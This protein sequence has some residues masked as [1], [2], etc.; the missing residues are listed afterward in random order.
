MFKEGDEQVV[1]IKA[2]EENCSVLLYCC[3]VLKDKVEKKE[4]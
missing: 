3:I 1:M 4:R 2:V